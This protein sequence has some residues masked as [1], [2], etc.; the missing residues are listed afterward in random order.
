MVNVFYLRCKTKKK[1]L[2]KQIF[3]RLLYN[4]IQKKSRPTVASQEGLP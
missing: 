2:T 4:N 3:S 1:S